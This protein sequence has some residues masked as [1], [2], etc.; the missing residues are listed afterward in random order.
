MDEIVGFM[1]RSLLFKIKEARETMRI[2]R[3]I[4]VLHNLFPDA[5]VDLVIPAN[6]ASTHLLPMYPNLIASCLL[7]FVHRLIR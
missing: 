3:L 2:P 7:G 6:Q 5:K 1:Y 4:Y